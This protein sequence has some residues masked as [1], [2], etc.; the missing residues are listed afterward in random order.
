VTE[1]GPMATITVVRTGRT[2]LSVR[3]ATSDG[4]AVAGTDYTSASGTLS[5]A[6][7]VVSRT[8]TVPVTNDTVG[9]ANE[10]VY[11]AL[12]S[13]V[14]AAVGT[15]G[16]A[17]LTI[18]DD[19]PVV[20]LSA[21]AY[22]VSEGGET[23]TITVVRTGRAP[24]AVQYATADGTA[25]AGSD[26]T[27]SSGVLSFAAGVT[28]RS[29]EVPIA[30][31]TLDEANETVYLA[32]SRPVGASL[33]TRVTA[34]LTITDDDTAGEIAFSAPVFT[35][36]E[37]GPMATVKVT[38][39]GGLASGATVSYATS[40]GT[41]T[42]PGDYV[43]SS[44]TLGFGAGETSRTLTVPVVDDLTPE[45]SE[46][47][48]LALSNPTG[49]A[50]LGGQAAATLVIVDTEATVEFSAAAS[51]ASEAGSAVR[52]STVQHQGW[53]LRAPDSDSANLE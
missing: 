34:V 8:F 5:F 28:S 16:S 23:A 40:D 4:T 18:T 31:D 43:A 33:G 27:T 41:A 48:N 22:T 15:R 13:P 53:S 12:S 37:S 44:G 20:Q 19:E 1:A 10:T 7:G 52:D 36:S 21:T 6:A 45:G 32:L 14:G 17:W 2:P 47:V 9:E 3:Y 35:A 11:L 39:S 51:R 46:T 38:R 25:T 29:F 24:F 30:S 49:G 50:T 42:S 26:Y